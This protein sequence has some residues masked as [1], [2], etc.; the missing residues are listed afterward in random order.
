LNHNNTGEGKGKRVPENPDG[1]D[2]TDG[3]GGRDGTDLEKA[4]KKGS[5]NYHIQGPDPKTSSRTSKNKPRTP[6]R[7]SQRGYLGPGPRKTAPKLPRG[8]KMGSKSLKMCK[9]DAKKYEKYP[10]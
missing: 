5:K 6:K 4:I 2:W 3:L 8:L 10:N 1:T 7:R 9:K